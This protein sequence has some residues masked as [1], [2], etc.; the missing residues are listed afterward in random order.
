MCGTEI[1]IDEGMMLAM[2]NCNCQ[3]NLETKETP[4]PITKEDYEEGIRVFIS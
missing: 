3:L 4:S 1:L 2:S